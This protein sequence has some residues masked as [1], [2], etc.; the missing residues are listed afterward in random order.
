MVKATAVCVSDSKRYWSVLVADRCVGQIQFYEGYGFSHVLGY[1]I[2]SKEDRC[3]GYMSAALRR[4]LDRLPLSFFPLR[5]WVLKDNAASI[6][7]LEKCGFTL[8]H[9]DDLSTHQ[10]RNDRV[11]W[12]MRNRNG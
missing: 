4:T 7:C 12:Y 10:I 1:H 8:I 5:A 2:N 9:P 6:R 3:R 11:D